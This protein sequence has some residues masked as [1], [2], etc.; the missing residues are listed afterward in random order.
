MAAEI[1]A[2]EQLRA[3]AFPSHEEEFVSA[4][5]REEILRETWV[6]RLEKD[7]DGPHCVD[8]L[9]GLCGLLDGGEPREQG[10][11]LP[12]FLQYFVS[13]LHKAAHRLVLL[14]ALPDSKYSF[15]GF[16]LKY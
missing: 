12:S 7:L 15:C 3:L 10:E 13:S 5:A 2:V 9:S 14:C 11:A 1:T 16:L 4:E 6:G 8:A